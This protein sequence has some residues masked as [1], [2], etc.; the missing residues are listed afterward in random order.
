VKGHVV[1]SGLG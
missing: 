1:P